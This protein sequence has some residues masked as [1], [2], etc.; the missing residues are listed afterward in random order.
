MAE[1]HASVTINAPVH[2][3][4]SL[5]THFNDFP[6][7]MHFVK[8]VTYYDDQRSHWVVQV[9]RRYE[10]DAIN[11]DWIEDRQIG[12]RS[13]RGLQNTGKVKFRPINSESTIVDI[14][15][16]YKPPTGPLGNF[17]ENLGVNSYFDSVLQRDL[18]HFA[19]MVELAPPGAMDPMSSHYLFHNESAIA[20]GLATERQK[21]SMAHDPLMSQEAL[22]E[23]QTRIEREAVMRRDAELQRE[24]ER[25]QQARLEREALLEHQ[26]KLER[27]A[28]R[29]KERRERMER[30]AALASDALQNHGV[31]PLTLAGRF[32]SYW[33][34]PK[35]DRDARWQDPLHAQDP[36]TARYPL[37]DSEATTEG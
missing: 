1:H 22:Q 2:Q 7:F 21:L 13:I 8:E 14:Y 29:E 6:K 4:Y 12:W 33:R 17:G 28:A 26:A 9:L 25:E 11:E 31:V 35:G 19:R 16:L 32:A 10:W 34:T 3:V 18:N 24:A 36:M 20:Q 5:F 15:I 27:E 23:R 37:N 30:E